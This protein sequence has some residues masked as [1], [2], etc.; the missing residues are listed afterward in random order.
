MDFSFE[1]QPEIASTQ[2]ARLGDMILACVPGEFTTMSG[3]RL[4]DRIK[5]KFGNTTTVVVVGLCN[6]YTDYITTPEEYTVLYFFR[7]FVLLYYTLLLI[8]W[9]LIIP[10]EIIYLNFWTLSQL[11]PAGHVLSSGRSQWETIPVK[12]F[13]R[14]IT[15]GRILSTVIADSR[16]WAWYLKKKWILNWSYFKKILFLVF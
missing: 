3:R 4:R 9:K 12:N 13:P 7:Y 10:F 1:W 14:K 11:E 8:M 6:T 2:M 16:N 15:M 5:A